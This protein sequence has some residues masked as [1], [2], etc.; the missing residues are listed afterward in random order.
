MRSYDG[1]IFKNHIP[2]DKD[3]A[4]DIWMRYPL[5]V[6]CIIANIEAQN[7]FF[8][9]EQTKDGSE[10]WDFIDGNGFILEPDPNDKKW[11]RVNII[12][13]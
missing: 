12:Y 4:A 1:K 6:N 7:P 10:V 13:D 5:Y 9:A 11:I 3:R 2:Y 8:W